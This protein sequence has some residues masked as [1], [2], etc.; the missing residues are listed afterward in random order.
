MTPAPPFILIRTPRLTLRPPCAGD[1]DSYAVAYE[2]SRSLWKPALPTID[3]SAAT[4]FGRI[5]ER[6]ET[7]MRQGTQLRLLGFLPDGRLAVVLALSEI[8]HGALESAYPGWRTSA[9]LT[10]KGL[11]TEGVAALLD[12]AFAPPPRGLGLHR[13][14]ANIMPANIA[15]IRVAEKTGFRKEGLAQ[16]YL[17]IDGKWQDHFMF[18]KVVDEHRHGANGR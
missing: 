12:L 18:A 11:A 13:V 14:Q 1:L 9:P 5:L 2:A 3:D 8:V 6:H 4:S 15:S 17:L 16:R 7:G 10:G